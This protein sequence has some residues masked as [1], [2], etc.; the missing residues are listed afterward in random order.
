MNAVSDAVLLTYLPLFQLTTFSL[1]GVDESLWHSGSLIFTAIVVLA[2]I[3]VVSLPF[4]LPNFFQVSFLI[5]QWTF[6]PVFLILIS[7][8]SWFLIALIVSNTI[9]ADSNWYHVSNISSLKLLI[10]LF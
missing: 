3:K 8:G 2:N 4:S 5:C 10:L 1:H 7:I 6:I 9:I